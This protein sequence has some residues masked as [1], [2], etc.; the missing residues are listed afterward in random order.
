M[1]TNT[2]LLLTLALSLASFSVATPVPSSH[3]SINRRSGAP[4]HPRHITP[5]LSKRAQR[6]SSEAADPTYQQPAGPLS[7]GSSPRSSPMQV[8]SGSD[9]SPSPQQPQHDSDMDA[10]GETDSEADAIGETDSEADAIGE[11]D[12]EA[13]AIGETDSE[14]DAIG[15]TDSEADAIGSPDSNYVAPSGGAGRGDGGQG[16]GGAQGQG[17]GRGRGT[18]A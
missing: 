15:E 2:P 5:S 3:S 8:D 10:E 12:S 1:K 6:G 9:R 16:R 17:A 4:A 13:D 7:D 18:N 14:A 11:T